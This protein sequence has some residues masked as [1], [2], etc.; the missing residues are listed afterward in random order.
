MR[1]TYLARTP[2]KS[3]ICTGACVINVL[4]W[5]YKLLICQRWK[6][7]KSPKFTWKIKCNLSQIFIYITKWVYNQVYRYH[8]HFAV[9]YIDGNSEFQVIMV[10]HLWHHKT[11]FSIVI[12]FT[13]STISVRSAARWNGIKCK[14]ITSP[15]RFVRN[16]ILLWFQSWHLYF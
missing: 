16:F 14:A 2:L 3:L 5:S 13:M 11:I 12:W 7:V 8:I 10:S 4:H 15:I 6:F 9:I 1:F